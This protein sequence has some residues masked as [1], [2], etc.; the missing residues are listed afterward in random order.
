MVGLS[1]AF[2]QEPL[3]VV[4]VLFILIVPFEK[5]FPRHQQRIRRPH[6]GTDVGYALASPLLN[7]VG[8]AAGLV[9]GVA[10]LAWLP[11]LLLR[12][13]VT[14]IPGPLLPIVGII[15]FDLTIYWTHRWYHEVP[16]LWRFH[17]IHHSTEHLDWVSGFRGH[18][19]DG[20]LIAPAF[21]FLVV[22]GFSPEFTGVLAAVQIITG[23]FLHAN[24]RWRLRWFHKLIITPEFHHWHHANE[25]GAINSNYSVFLPLWDLVFGTYFMPSDRRP[26]RYGVSEP[27]PD[28]IVLQLWHPLRGMDNP[29]RVVA[30]PVR[31]LKGLIRFVRA[32]VRDMYRSATRPRSHVPTG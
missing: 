17:S 8:L 29:L 22:A 15:L 1:L 10:S 12:P 16:F 7:A 2:D 27:I 3:G 20:T 24:V 11:G 14:Q 32:L 28:G 6:L 21:V 23:L 4:V 25:P 13:F 19:L 31:S 30:H 18:P 5:L 9:V 26:S